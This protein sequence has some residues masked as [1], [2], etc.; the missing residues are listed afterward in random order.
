MIRKLPERQGAW[1]ERPL[2]EP[3]EPAGHGKATGLDWPEP[4]GT[5]FQVEI[6][7]PLLEILRP[8]DRE[9]AIH[10]S[11]LQGF[12][13]CVQPN[14]ARSCVFRYRRDGKP[15]RVTLGK[16]GAVKADHG[17]RLGARLGE[18]CR[19]G[20]D[21]VIGPVLYCEMCEGPA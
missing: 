4:V 2:S 3:R 5:R 19:R 11:A 12:M 15:R 16:P 7:E 18:S 1:R 9:Y 10:E 14:G 17:P 13:L 6:S 8:R 21:G 20:D